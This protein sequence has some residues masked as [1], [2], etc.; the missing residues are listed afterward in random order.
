[1]DLLSPKIIICVNIHSVGR[2]SL[3]KLI[4]NSLQNEKDFF[5]K[6]FFFTKIPCT[7]LLYVPSPKH[8]N[9]HSLPSM[10]QFWP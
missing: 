1:M 6:I 3:D 8:T 4:Q 2:Q 10:L 5:N 7:I 9:T